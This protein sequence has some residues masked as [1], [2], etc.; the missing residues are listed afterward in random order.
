MSYEPKDKMTEKFFEE[1]AKKILNYLRR[2]VRYDESF[3][4]RPFFIE[5]FGSPSAGKT[6]TI[7]EA[8]KFLRRQNF[9]VLRPQEGAEVIRHIERTTPL[10]NLRTAI[11]ALAELID[12]SM[13]H[14][15]D[16]VIFDRCIYDAYC[17]ML[18]WQEKGKLTEVETEMFQAFFTS[19]FWVDK[20]DIAYLMTC[21]AEKAMERE[22]RI[23]LSS[24]LGETTNPETIKKLINRC[25]KTF[26]VLSPSHPQ[27]RIFD[28][29][30]M[31]EQ[32]MIQNIAN[33]IL[34]TLESKIQ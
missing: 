10:Y 27:L 30:N 24:K 7:T 31:D 33:D 28:T 19:R 13:G 2:D 11:Y 25:K 18:Y 5:F 17:W 22:M 16:V 15:Y 14:L 8:D 20:I 29:T 1:K 26:T 12:K 6:T 3:L 32:E 34:Q 23:A 21:D 9:R 4:P